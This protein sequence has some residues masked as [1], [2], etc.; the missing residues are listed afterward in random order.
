MQKRRGGALILII[1]LIVIAAAALEFY[2][3]NGKPFSEY[4]KP[5]SNRSYLTYE[6]HLAA[7]EREKRISELKT[8]V[9]GV[10]KGFTKN[11]KTR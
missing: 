10:F 8:K 4:T 3:S 11:S 1:L 5:S 6:E 2:V 9:Q 7:K